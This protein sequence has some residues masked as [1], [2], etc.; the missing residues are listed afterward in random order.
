MLLISATERCSRKFQNFE[1]RPQT[2]TFIFASVY[3]QV[4]TTVVRSFP[5]YTK[6]DVVSIA[7][8]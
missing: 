3:L 2:R 4:Q 6:I 1:K 5:E 7:K 8:G